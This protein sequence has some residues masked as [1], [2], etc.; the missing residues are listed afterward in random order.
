MNATETNTSTTAGVDIRSSATSTVASRSIESIF[1]PRSVAIIGASNDSSRIGGRPIRYLQ[2]SG[3]EGDIYPVNPNRDA[4]QGLRSYPS[5]ES[6]PA[7]VDLAIIAVPA[8]MV[9]AAVASCAACGVRAA[10]VFSAGFAEVS[11]DGASSQREM[12]AAARQSGMRILGPNCLGVFNAYSRFTGTFSQA[13]RNGLPPPGP[14][15]IA[16]QSG[17]CGAH[18]AYLC[19]QRGIGIGYWVTT[20]NEADISLSECMLWLARSPSVRVIAAYAEAIRD[21]DRFVEALRVARENGKA[22]V[23]LKVGR[24]AAGARAA[25]S[26]TGALAGEDA[27]YDAVLTQFGVHRAATIEELLDIAYACT[28]GI[29]PHD[30]T[31]GIVT[32]SGGV[33][34]QMADAA[35]DY[36]LETPALPAQAQASIKE[37][38]PFAGVAN[39]I[40]MTA[41]ATNDKRLLTRCLEIAVEEGGFSSIALFLSSAP[42]APDFVESHLGLLSALRQR[43]PDKLLVV[44]CIAPTEVVR[45][46]EAAGFLVFEDPTHAIRAIGALARFAAGFASAGAARRSEACPAPRLP[47]ERV[48]SLRD[49]ADLDEHRAKSLLAEA[50]IPVHRE[51]LAKNIDEVR[52]AASQFNAPV[53][54]KVVSPDIQHKTEVGGVAL[55][56]PSSEQ[57]A[58]VA[59]EMLDRIRSLRPEARLTGILVSPMCQGGIETICGTFAD[60]VFGPVVVFGLG[61]IHVEV[62]KDVAMRLAPID[63]Q[64]ALS[65]VKQV[66]GAA[67]FAGVRGAAPADIDALATAIARLSQFA[68]ANRDVIGEIDVNPLLVMPEGQGAYA[69]DALVLPHH[70]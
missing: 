23:M 26:H 15:A 44:S 65:M 70:R 34:V 22:V 3:F 30:G 7:R 47:A 21:G 11:E 33:G 59:E 63:K 19:Q 62:L 54:L 69:L 5:I 25:A 61:G 18:L 12:L 9:P 28:P 14:L 53:V 64:E 39:P 37:M 24:T 13:I 60:P 43:H 49:L 38:I 27:V 20:G 1:E 2:D 57:A 41:Q 40:D 4:V 46:L 31:L 56:V 36:G 32:G 67:M 17:A 29:F 51:C 48:L 42:A 6:V 58:V 55:N 52:D 16:S 45:K 10:V 8:E 35:F 50:G 66:R 68:Y